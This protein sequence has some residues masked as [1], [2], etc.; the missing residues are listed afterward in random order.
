MGLGHLELVPCLHVHEVQLVV[1]LCV[2]VQLSGETIFQSSLLLCGTLVDADL[3]RG[4]LTV[5]IFCLHLLR[6]LH[7]HD[8]I[9]LELSFELCVRHVSL[10]VSCPHQGL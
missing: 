10:V 2:F 6:K 7:V 3:V 5:L 1:L 8:P 9:R 4:L